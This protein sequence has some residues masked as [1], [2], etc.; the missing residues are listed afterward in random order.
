MI[1]D[2]S[3]LW[4]HDYNCCSRSYLQLY[5]PVI[6]RNRWSQWWQL[7]TPKGMD[8]NLRITCIHR[9][10]MLCSGALWQEHLNL[11]KFLNWLRWKRDGR[12]KDVVQVLL[13]STY[14][15]LWGTCLMF[16]EC[17][18]DYLLSVCRAHVKTTTWS[19]L[20]M[21]RPIIHPSAYSVLILL[22]TSC[23]TLLLLLSLFCHHYFRC[24]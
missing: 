7:G 3:T 23:F 11:H 24:Y 5:A 22:V 15:Y 12:T 6:V 17:L 8:Y 1:S 4:L 14:N 13:A 2:L 21:Q 18:D 10:L 9:V 19:I 20:S 16:V